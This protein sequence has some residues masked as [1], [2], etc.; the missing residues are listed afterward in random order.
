MSKSVKCAVCGGKCHLHSSL[1]VLFEIDEGNQT[2]ICDEKGPKAKATFA[3]QLNMFK[4][5][6]RS[7]VSKICLDSDASKLFKPHKAKPGCLEGVGITGKH[8]G[9]SMSINVNSNE[10]QQIAINLFLLN[11]NDTK[12]N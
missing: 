7:V 5:Q 10:Q 9:L 11:H 3:K 2:P 1:S 8:Q 12:K 4:R 6:L